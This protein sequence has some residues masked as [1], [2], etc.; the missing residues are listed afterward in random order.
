MRKT[1]FITLLV[2][3]VLFFPTY[4]ALGETIF[5]PKQYIQTGSSNTNTYTDTFSA[6]P[7]QGT[8]IALNG[9]AGGQRRMSSANQCL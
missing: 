5:G 6:T 8:L 2:V 1:V 9:Q 7:G 4:F 3:L